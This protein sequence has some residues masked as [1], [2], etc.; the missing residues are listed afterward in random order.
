MYIILILPAFHFHIDPGFIQSFDMAVLLF[1]GCVTVWDLP[2]V[3][4]EM[5]FSVQEAYRRVALGSIPK[6]GDVSSNGQRETLSVLS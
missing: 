2:E 5:E 4:F 1:K 6:E 3:N